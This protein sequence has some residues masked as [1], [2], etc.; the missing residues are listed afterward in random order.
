[1]DF[2]SLAQGF[3]VPAQQ[4]F[5]QQGGSIFNLEALCVCAA[6][7]VPGCA[8]KQHQHCPALQLAL[9]TICSQLDVGLFRLLTEC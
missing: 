9:S 7:S 2:W 1:M 3:Q 6:R 5:I 8:H 4:I